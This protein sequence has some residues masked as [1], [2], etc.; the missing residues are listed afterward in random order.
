[1]IT[2]ITNITKVASV[3]VVGMVTVI[4]SMLGLPLL[5]RLPVLI[6]NMQELFFSAEFP[7]LFPKEYNLEKCSP[8]H[9][10]NLHIW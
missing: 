4:P 9:I 2:V 1:M 8:Y 10:Q 5:P 6:V 7:I 3:S